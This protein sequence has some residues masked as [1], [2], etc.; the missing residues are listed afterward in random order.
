MAPTDLHRGNWTLRELAAAHDDL[1]AQRDAL[2]ARVDQ[3]WVKAG[4]LDEVIRRIR[5]GGVTLVEVVEVIDEKVGIF[6]EVT[7]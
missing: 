1:E 7:P 5:R 3:L 4:C 2:A 6:A